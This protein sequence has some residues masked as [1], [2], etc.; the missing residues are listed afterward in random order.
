MENTSK[1]GR[2]KKLVEKG[3]NPRLK[4]SAAKNPTKKRAYRKRRTA[5]AHIR[6]H[7]VKNRTYYSYVR[8]S[9]KEIYLGD[10]DAILKAVRAMK[11]GGIV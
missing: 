11:G 6:P 3:G 10:A 2:D 1:N 7:K 4:N 8:G 9:D 5:E